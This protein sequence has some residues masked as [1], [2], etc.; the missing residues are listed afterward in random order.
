MSDISRRLPLLHLIFYSLLLISTPFLLLKNYL[1]AAIGRFSDLSFEI[2]SINIPIVLVIAIILLLALFLKYRKSLNRKRIIVI[3]MILGMLLIGQKSTDFYF[4]HRFYELQ[5]NW[6]YLAYCFYT[7]FAYRYFY[8]RSLSHSRIILYTFLVAMCVSTFDEFVQVPLS[9]RIFDISDIAKDL[10]GTSIGLIIIYFLIFEGKLFTEEK[11]IR[12]FRIK[13]YINNPFTILVYIIIFSYILLF[14]G[15]LL[16]SRE[17]L[18]SSIIISFSIFIIVF[19]II[20]LTQFKYLKYFFLLATI[21][22]TSV[23]AFKILTSEQVLR[24]NNKGTILFHN[25]PLPYFDLM[26]HN[27]GLLRFTDK[28]N[29]FN[30]RDQNTIFSYSEDILIIGNGSSDK[31]IMGFPIKSQ[32]QFVYNTYTKRG[33]QVIITELNLAVLKY[34]QL[35]KEGYNVVFI[36]HR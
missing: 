9:N 30:G 21:L 8:S 13:D 6:H 35:K 5:H 28:K 27:N 19:I 1:Q 7:I 34:N 16:S 22:L 12:N 29:F 11:K 26:I 23:G 33:L 25:I 24:I 31:E 36:I 10:W 32:T 17:Y 3:F 15:S 20:H 2:A 14:T 4:N 18:L